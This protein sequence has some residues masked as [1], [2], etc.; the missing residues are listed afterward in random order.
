M[1][2]TFAVLGGSLV[3]AQQAVTS[4]GGDAT[5]S[6]GSMSYTLG[7]PVV[8]F[9][10]APS[11][12]AS[13]GVQ[14]SYAL[15]STSLPPQEDPPPPVVIW[16]NPTSAGLSVAFG[17]TPPQGSTY[18]VMDATRRAVLAGKLEANT[19]IA[20]EQLSTAS[21][22]LQLFYGPIPATYVF[23]KQ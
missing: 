9:N 11:G 20:T 18:T 4:T 3:H 16:P 5:G 14:R 22:T 10:T 13:H 6:G 21:Y 15:I 2:L 8:T 19:S 1:I 23:I 17:G 12:S 7:E